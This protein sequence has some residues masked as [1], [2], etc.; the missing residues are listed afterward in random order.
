MDQKRL[1]FEPLSVMAKLDPV[2][3]TVTVAKY[4]KD[5]NLLARPGWRSLQRIASHEVKFARMLIQAK[6]SQQRHGPL[7]KFGIQILGPA[8]MLWNWML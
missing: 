3:V 1:S 8:N 6:L 4:T 7:F 2:T 5:N